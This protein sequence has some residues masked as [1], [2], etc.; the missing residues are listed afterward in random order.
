MKEKSIIGVDVGGT[1]IH[2]ARIEDDKVVAE[3]RIPTAASRDRDEIVKDLSDGIS[4]VLNRDVIGIGIGIP[5]LVDVESGVI[6]NVQNIPAWKDL[7]IREILQ[8][9]F[10]L[11]VYVGND[12]NCFALGEKY[13]GKAKGYSN[14]VALSLGTGVGAGVIINNQLYI[15][16]G[17]LAGEF[18]GIKYL[19]SEYENYCSSKFFLHKYHI[20]AKTL[21]ERAARKENVAIDI[22]I[23]FGNHVG[24][25]I[26]SVLYSVGP[27]VII[28][29]GS[30]SK[31]FPYF[32][33][34]M[35]ESLSK[36][37][38]TQALE[39]TKIDVS[40]NSEIPVLGAGALVLS[41]INSIGI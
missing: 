14:V 9:I 25:L 21:A 4:E 37:P 29:G 6:S 12:A 15:G 34:G 1:K 5:G 22:F 31:A 33:K 28:I 27:D 30:L 18:G 2:I 13:F 16:N 3:L 32:K 19:D 8:G 20:D 36:F 10:G 17:S 41:A 38:H 35:L 26:Q 7:P 39:S 24:N 11:P 23:E 40:G